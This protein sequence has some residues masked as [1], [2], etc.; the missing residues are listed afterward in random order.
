MTRNHQ[1]D[2][3]VRY[4]DDAVIHCQTKEKAQEM[5]KALEIRPKEI[6]PEIHPQKTKIVYCHQRPRPRRE[7][8]VV[9]FDFLGCTFKPRKVYRRGRC[10]TGFLPAVSNKAKKGMV[11]KIR[12]WGIRPRSDKKITEIAKFCNPAIRGWINYYGKYYGSDLNFTLRK[13]NN[14]LIN[15]A[16]RTLKKFKRSYR[17]A[18]RWP[19]RMARW[20]PELFVHW[21][22]IPP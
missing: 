6:G 13:I 19:K 9:T 15:W 10:Y 1:D 16:R 18:Y 4:A 21:K 3:F 5:K 8:E 20:Y 17:K 12:D 7:K 11:K 14:A 22:K 2:P